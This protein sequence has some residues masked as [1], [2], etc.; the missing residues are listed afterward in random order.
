MVMSPSYQN[1]YFYNFILNDVSAVYFRKTFH[2]FVSLVVSLLPRLK[3]VPMIRYVCVLIFLCQ[4]VTCNKTISKE[5]S[6]LI[7]VTDFNMT[8]KRAILQK[9]TA[10]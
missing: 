7:V 8:S 9:V 6:S 3:D 4:Q 10:L 1:T 5:K 2:G